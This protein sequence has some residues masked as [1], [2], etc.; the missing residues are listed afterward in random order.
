MKQQVRNWM[1]ATLA[2]S[3][4]LTPNLFQ[5]S[6]YAAGEGTVKQSNS[7]VAPF[8][9]LNGVSPEQM[10][11][12][13]Q[14]LQAGLLK[15]D[16]AGTFRPADT[17]T[18]E[19]MAVLL[20]QSLQLPMGQAATTFSDV[21]P[22]G[23]AS[24][25]IEAV[26]K[27]GLMVGDGD[28]AFRPEAPVTRE[29]MAALLM[30]AA[31]FPLA[32]GT[33]SSA[34]SDWNTVSQWAKPFVNTAL[35][36][37]SLK[38]TGSNF[39]PQSPVSRQEIAEM[40]LDT[41]FPTDR[42]ALLQEVE[43]GKVKI[44]GISY[45]LSDSVKGLLQPANRAALQG[46]SIQFSATD[47]T[48]QS[49][50][51]LELHASGQAPADK[52]PEFS[53][54]LVL[55]GH[56]ATLDGDLVLSG[57][58]L[59]V[60][61]LNV[62]K[63]FRITPELAND[64]SARQLNVLGK[65]LIQGGDEDTV[66]FADSKLQDVE[67]SKPD[68][69]LVAQENSSLQNLTVS[70]NATL[71]SD[72][73]SLL[74]KVTVADGAQEVKLQ[75]TMQDVVVNS[76]QPTTLTGNA[77][78]SN[79]VVNTAAPLK[80][81]G[82]GSVANLQVNNPGAQVKVASTLTV[83]NVAYAAGVP[84]NTVAGVT[85]PSTPTTPDP[86]PNT[87]PILVTPFSDQAM[88]AGDSV[89]SV[90]VLGHFTDAEQSVLKYT[91]S[92]SN[93][94]ICKATLSGNNIQLTP[95][96]RGTVTIYVTADD[97]HGEQTS[98]SF[99]VTVND[100]PRSS[101]IPD[102]T[103]TLGSGDLTLSL[104]SFITDA[105]N[106]PLAYEVSVADPNIASYSLNSDQLVLKP[107]GVGSTTVTVKATDGRGGTL[108]K[109]FQLNVGAQPNQNPVVDQ[110]PSDQTIT[111]GSADYTLDAAT[112][113]SDPDHD[114]LTYDAV[115]LD[116]SIATVTRNGSQIT[117]HAVAEG[118][119]KIQL[120][121]MDG[122]GGEVTTEFN[123]TVKPVP[124]QNNHD[125]QAVATIYEQVL[126]AGVTNA[127]SYDLSQLFEDQDGDALTFTAVP[128]TPG[129][130]NADVS[131]AAITLSA[132]STAGST[133]VVITAD[134]GKGGTATY[135][136]IVHNA[137]LVPG[138]QLNIHTKQGV[139]DD[140]TVDLSKFFPGQ[141]SFQVYSGT[142]DSTF[143][144]P[145]PLSGNTWKWNGDT[146]LD[147]WVI[148][149]DGTAVVLHVSADPQGAED[150]YFSQYMDMGNGRTALQLYFNP[151]GDTSQ[152]VSGYSLEVHQHNLKTNQET[153]YTRAMLPLWKGMPYLFID[154]TFYDLF[155]IAPVQYFNDELILSDPGNSYVTGFVLKKN[156][157]TI[158]VLGNPNS[159][160]Q[161]MP[162]GGTFIRKK[163]IRAGSSTF[164]LYGE[165]NSYPV[166]TL[167][168]LG[169]HTP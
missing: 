47:R 132:G 163:G 18:R 100:P 99:N 48:V 92:T 4:V 75:G 114:T 5:S 44:N 168:Y 85:D 155:D 57:N 83:S 98:T 107:L 148:G 21:L 143:T 30:R 11:K 80:L 52:A 51:K 82:T 123:V 91:V 59:S 12:I 102:Q 69:H 120:K 167:Q 149:A 32:E 55:D 154:R 79:V 71:E 64:F 146:L 157:V 42:P 56:G 138:G 45:R 78:I 1:I 121:A 38:T 53:G 72:D 46:A 139:N 35:K 118:A 156:G 37:G 34:V 41:F 66:A 129:I 97:L 161:F 61:N 36:T 49:I 112:L 127:R 94:L 130:V 106:D 144:G 131:G 50:T 67:V 70:A 25:Y 16:A 133:T 81:N 126:T 145:T 162:D 23:W 103:V 20:T 137:P 136:L 111:L 29:E 31:Q 13:L 7:S 160:A 152:T 158:D 74:Q 54:N 159:S 14:A 135:N 140:I 109:S 84:T 33:E 58:Y 27:A 6:A 3:T 8:S 104:N 39:H 89:M 93:R 65:T 26:R 40:L 28:G 166:G 96:S 95:M 15:G 113:F 43:D 88:T 124:S 125:P 110:T 115:S 122:N 24:R 142:P 76:T 128:Q 119:T 60:Q 105:D 19:E 165:W 22:N 9:D 86:D 2:L 141:T 87:A 68:V 101:G 108:T 117:V 10:N 90:N 73:S 151:V 147:Y 77:S 153:F 134:D 17:L 62:K 164:S 63:D 116:P 150:L 169:T